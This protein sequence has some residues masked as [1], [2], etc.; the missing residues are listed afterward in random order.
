M[1]VRPRRRT[2]TAVLAGTYL[3]LSPFIFGM[4]WDAKIAANATLVGVCIVLLT[5]WGVLAGGSRV[6][7]WVKVSLAGWLLVSPVALGA[8]ESPSALSACVVGALILAS[9]DTARVALDLTAFLRTKYLSYLGRM[10]RPELTP[11]SVIRPCAPEVP[12]TPERLAE[13]ITE[14]TDQ[15]RR[16]LLKKPSELELEMC[17]VGYAKCA[18]DAITL[19]RLVQEETKSSCPLRQ[20]KMKVALQQATDSLFRAREAFPSR[21][22]REVG[23]DR[24]DE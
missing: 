13:H 1:K 9:T 16:T 14:S 8:A 7:R 20:L 10:L 5:S 4:T 2:L 17:A 3:A 21:V 15:I 24:G 6:A 22:P 19:V 12:E 18:E 11:E 23:V